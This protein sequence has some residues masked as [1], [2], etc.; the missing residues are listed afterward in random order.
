MRLDRCDT[1]GRFGE[2]TAA[3]TDVLESA[4]AILVSDYGRGITALPSVRRALADAA[5]R[6]RPVVWDP[7]PK[8]STPV[9]GVRLACPNRAEASAFC[10]LHGADL[11]GQRGGTAGE[12]ALLRAAW[13]VSAVAV[14]VG[15]DG[16]VLAEPDSTPIAVPAPTLHNGDTCGAGDRFAATAASWLADRHPVAAAVAAAVRSASAYVADDGPGILTATLERRANSWLT[17]HPYS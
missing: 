12:A 15:C 2:L 8:G 7:H 10:A 5:D 13:R 4:A 17:Q 3:A 1:P 14:T 11:N 6:G 9:P 16:A